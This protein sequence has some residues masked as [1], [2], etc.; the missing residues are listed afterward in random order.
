VFTARHLP[1]DFSV[2]VGVHSKGE[3][4]MSA[5]FNKMMIVGAS[6]LALSVMA[7]SAS[8]APSLGIGRPYYG[9]S[10]Q[11]S[12]FN[13]TRNIAPAIS[14][15]TRQSYSYEPAEGT[16]KATTGCNRNAAAPQ[17][18]KKDTSKDEV[19]MAPPVTRHSY[20]YEPAVP[21]V[22]NYSRS[23]APTKDL[24]QYPKTDPRRYNH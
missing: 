7:S 14:T 9:S 20:S 2:G 15:E 13:V 16:T 12:G 5:T 17:A 19:A 24:W 8:A 6:V 21:S 18:V 22:R 23:T 1:H 4:I 3:I 11:R 10:N